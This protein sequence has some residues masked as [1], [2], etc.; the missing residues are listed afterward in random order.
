MSFYEYSIVYFDNCV[1]NYS[2]DRTVIN[3]I[4]SLINS[5][6]LPIVYSLKIQMNGI[7]CF[8]AVNFLKKALNQRSID[9]QHRKQVLIIIYDHPFV[10]ESIKV[11][12]SASNRAFFTRDLKGWNPYNEKIT[13][14]YEIGDRIY[15]PLD[16]VPGLNYY[17]SNSTYID[18]YIYYL[19]LW[20]LFEIKCLPILFHVPMHVTESKMLQAIE[21]LNTY[22]LNIR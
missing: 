19:S 2:Q 12:S 5:S 1:V 9:F 14:D 16:N 7:D 8:E 15:S 3:A 6:N 11:V 17:E 20:S 10:N 4:E 13:N 22:F 21:K 18:N